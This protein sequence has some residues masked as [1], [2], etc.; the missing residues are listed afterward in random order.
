MTNWLAYFL[1]GV[2]ITLWFIGLVIIM[3]SPR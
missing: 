2:G 1:F 3:A